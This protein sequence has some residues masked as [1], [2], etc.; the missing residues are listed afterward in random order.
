MPS[1]I[2]SCSYC[3]PWEGHTIFA[4]FEPLLFYLVQQF[5]DHGD[6]PSGLLHRIVSAFIF[7]FRDNE[8]VIVRSCDH[9]NDLLIRDCGFMQILIHVMAFSVHFKAVRHDPL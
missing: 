8:S 1:G 7:I 2:S 3:C 5:L 9:R 6:M 4:R